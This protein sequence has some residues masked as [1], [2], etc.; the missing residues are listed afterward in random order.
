ML[1]ALLAGADPA[2]FRAAEWRRGT[3]PPYRLGELALDDVAGTVDA[4][5]AVCRP[6][7]TGPADTVD[8]NVDL[9]DGR[10]LTGTVGGVHGTVVARS[11]F[12]RLAPKHR[13]TAWVHLLAVAASDRPGQWQ[14]ISTGRGRFRSTPAW[15]STINAPADALEQL[16]RLVDLRDRGLH[17]PLP[18]A[19][20]A[21]AEYAERRHRGDSVE[22]GVDAA[23]QEFG[24]TYGERTDRHITYLYG[25]GVTLRDL[26]AVAARDDEQAW[27]GEPT[28]FGALARRLW[29]PLLSNEIQGV[30]EPNRVEVRPARGAPDGH[31]RARGQRGNRQDLRH[32][33]PGHP[34][35]RRGGGG[36]VAAA[37]GDV[38]PRR[39]AGTARTHPGPV[40]R[41]RAGAGRPGGR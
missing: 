32:R 8:V 34:V 3:L 20:A 6:I 39:D 40:R 10:R 5:V 27:H 35:R 31:H 19:T 23:A 33:R 17:E 29:E 4:L 9:G 2:D 22:M 26:T 28:R 25:S 7:Y 11:T 18:T 36:A 16:T 38:Q 1:E 12:S 30:R 21:A 13:L 15:R 14:A 41:R 37:A 24:S